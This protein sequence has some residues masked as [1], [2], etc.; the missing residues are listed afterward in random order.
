MITSINNALAKKR[1][2]NEKGFTLIELLVVIL[3]I[4]VLA[5]I[6]IPAFLNQRQ[7]AWES[8]VKSD[9]ANAVIAAETYSTN[10]NGSYA[11]MDTAVLEANGFKPTDGV[12]ITVGLVEDGYTLTAVHESL[13]NDWVFDSETG[14]TTEDGAVEDDDE[15]P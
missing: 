9:L 2:E 3:I 4:G 14:Q 6:A 1:E 12:T 15:T 10:N 8:Q 5:A 13:D 7:G 11:A